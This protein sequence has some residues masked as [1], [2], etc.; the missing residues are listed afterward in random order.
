LAQFN[1]AVV[2]G[3][4]DPGGGTDQNCALTSIHFTIHGSIDTT[5]TV[6][7]TSGSDASYN[8]TS[9]ATLAIIDG[10]SP[11][12]T[13]VEALPTTSTSTGLIAN[14]STQTGPL[15]T[16]ADGDAKYTCIGTTCT[17]ASVTPAGTPVS[18]L[19][20]ATPFL[21]TGTLTLFAAGNFTGSI[22]GTGFSGSIGGT[23]SETVTIQYDYSYNE[24]IP[25]STTP[26]PVSM[27]L[28][29]GGLIALGLLRKRLK[30]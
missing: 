29:G 14:G 5:Y 24:V 23:G 8:I 19:I 3:Q 2:N 12:F 22:G 13:F 18:S 27:A 6:K 10:G 4:S 25:S 26:E 28:V 9:S 11:A 30:S 7:N 21:G 15:S 1:C 17:L 16:S 20:D